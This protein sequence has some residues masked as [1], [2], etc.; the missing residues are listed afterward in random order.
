MYSFCGKCCKDICCPGRQSTRCCPKLIV[1]ARASLGEE[2]QP[3][4]LVAVAVLA[5]KAPPEA[6][7]AYSLCSRVLNTRFCWERG[8]CFSGGSDVN[9]PEAK[10][11][12][13]MSSYCCFS[14]RLYYSLLVSKRSALGKQYR[15]PEQVLTQT[16]QVCCCSLGLA[17]MTSAKQPALLPQACSLEPF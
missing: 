13:K 8:T 5:V 17:K 12:K 11:T 3:L 10:S 6:W 2:M 15:W 9:D 1:H 14:E 4:D 16:V 7:L